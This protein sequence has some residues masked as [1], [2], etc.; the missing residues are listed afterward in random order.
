MSRTK[1]PFFSLF[2][3]A[4]IAGG[5]ALSEDDAALQK[6]RAKIDSMFEEI[7]PENVNASPIDG[8]YTVQKGSIVAYVSADGRYLLQGD[9]IDLDEQVNLSERSRVDARRT[10]ISTIED[11][12]VIMFSP[13]EVK[14]SVTVFTDVECTYCR[15]LHSQMDEYLAQGIEIRYLLYPRNGPASSS[16]GVSENVWCARDRNSA[17]TAAKLGRSFES[18]KCDATIVTNHYMMG[19]NVGLTGTPAIV[20]DDGTLISGYLAPAALSSRLQQDAAN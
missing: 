20:L 8:W 6:V 3:V 18:D 5:P 11:D 16:W 2:A 10:L 1:I 19:Q 4:L 13:E 12:E 7:G 9:L 15:K 17:L 14:F